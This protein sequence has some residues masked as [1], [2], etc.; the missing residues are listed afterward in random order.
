MSIMQWNKHFH[1]DMHEIFTQDD[2]L[3]PYSYITRKT[4]DIQ[5]IGV[6]PQNECFSEPYQYIQ[7]ELSHRHLHSNPTFADD[8]AMFP[9]FRDRKIE[10]KF[11]QSANEISPQGIPWPSLLRV[12]QVSDDHRAI[13][14]V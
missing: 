6:L 13:K 5:R 14:Y 11:K 1:E 10:I 9:I 7:D 12:K 2:I 3:V 4:A 8:N